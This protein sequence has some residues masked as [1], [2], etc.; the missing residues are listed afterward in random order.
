[1]IGNKIMELN[2]K[3]YKRVDEKTINITPLMFD[4][5][6]ANIFGLQAKQPQKIQQSIDQIE[7]LRK[8]IRKGD[9]FPPI[10]IE[11]NPKTNAFITIVDGFHRLI[12]YRDECM[13]ITKAIY[14][15]RLD[16]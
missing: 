6:E 9:T 13:T 1:M 8:D 14:V 2:Y 15:T 16:R 12:A 7:Q 11:V 10:I 4:L 3:K 5:A